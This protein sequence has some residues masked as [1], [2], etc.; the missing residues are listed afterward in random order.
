MKRR[1]ANLTDLAM[2][3]IEMQAVLARRR[4]EWAIGVL[5]DSKATQE[6]IA[7]ALAV[8]EGKIGQEAAQAILDRGHGKPQQKVEVDHRHVFDELDDDER[9][10]WMID[11]GQRVMKDIQDR[12]E[13]KAIA[14]PKKPLV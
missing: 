7:A 10:V 11:L 12:R 8:A 4:L 9:E 6:E 14:P 13:Q 5:H 2:D 3:I 1:A